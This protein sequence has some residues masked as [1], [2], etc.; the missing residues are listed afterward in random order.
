MLDLEHFQQD[1]KTL[2]R[3]ALSDTGK[4]DSTHAL[5]KQY[6]AHISE[7]CYAWLFSDECNAVAG[8]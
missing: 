2:S 5:I 7:E 4:L 3:S 1:Y 8:E 6:Y